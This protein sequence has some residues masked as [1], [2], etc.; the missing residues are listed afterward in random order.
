MINIY[1]YN[2]YI[3]IYLHISLYVYIYTKYV[4]VYIHTGYPY[5]LN[6]R[7]KLKLRIKNLP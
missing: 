3:Y 6:E 5:D 4:C 1:I 7:N 2:K